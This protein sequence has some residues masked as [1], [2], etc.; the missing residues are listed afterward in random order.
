MRTTYTTAI[1][2]GSTQIAVRTLQGEEDMLQWL[3]PD[4]LG[5]TSATANADGRWNS[6]LQYSAFGEIRAS[7][8]LTLTEFRYT[9]QLRQAELGLYYYV[10]RWYDP[11]IAHFVQTD[12]LVPN[13]FDLETLDRYSYANN[14]PCNNTDPSG[15]CSVSLMSA[16]S[17]LY[18]F[19][20]CVQDY[21]D[22]YESFKKGNNDAGILYLEVTGIKDTIVDTADNVHQLNSDVAAVFSNAP[23]SE[24]IMPSIRLGTY[25]VST[26]AN[27]VGL[28]QAGRGVLAFTRSGKGG[29]YF[30]N[31]TKYLEEFDKGD[32]LFRVFGGESLR[33]GKWAF[34]KNPGN[35]INAIRTGALPPSNSP[36]SITKITFN[37][38]VIGEVSKAARLFGQPGGG[39]QVALPM[40][41]ATVFS[42]GKSLPIGFMPLV[43]T[44]SIY[45]FFQGW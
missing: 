7:S 13:I 2:T 43:P 26:A 18:M 21:V 42:S 1:T 12:S 41:P 45:N 31:G 38:P 17:P 10:A 23:L 33:D 27:A 14:N 44:N 36:T 40:S 30:V 37:N 24:R 8:G 20:S 34:I 9:G 29:Q 16:L 4:H 35:Q 28:V 25:A 15:H 39:T 19:I 5:S 22:A 3:L 32:E 6:T 11:E